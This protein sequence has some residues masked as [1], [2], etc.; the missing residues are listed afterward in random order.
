MKI[1]IVADSPEDDETARQLTI[2]V[3]YMLQNPS[4]EMPTD[5]KEEIRSE[6]NNLYI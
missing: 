6:Y 2:L 1:T 5:T 4:E 3:N